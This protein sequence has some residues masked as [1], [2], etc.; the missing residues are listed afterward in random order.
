MSA[1]V[2]QK[3]TKKDRDDQIFDV[4]VKQ[5][6]IP[7][8][9]NH[10]LSKTASLWKIDQRNWDGNFHSEWI[11]KPHD[12]SPHHQVREKLSTDELYELIFLQ[13]REPTE[14]EKQQMVVRMESELAEFMRKPH[15]STFPD[16]TH[17]KC[18]KTLRQV[19]KFLEHKYNTVY[20]QLAR[21]RNPK[22]NKNPKAKPKA[23]PKSSSSFKIGKKR[24]PPGCVKRKVSRKVSRKR[25]SV[26]RKASRKRRSVKRK[27]SRK[28][29]S[30]KRKVSRKVSRKRRSVKRS[31]KKVIGGKMR[32]I[33][34]SKNPSHMTK[35]GP[36]DLLLT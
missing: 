5:R 7:I 8:P 19:L 27:A 29:R 22:R 4:F 21:S 2:M 30:V 35:I 9:I 20:S 28:R 1:L 15:E 25:R 14:E 16:D 17:D 11:I 3:A 32:T 10:H 33:H 13:P 12:H 34:K 18:Q 36:R 23:K 24:C 26:K 6:L 31:R